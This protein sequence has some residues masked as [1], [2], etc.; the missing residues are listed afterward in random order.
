MPLK[1]DSSNKAR[2][3]NMEIERKAG[4]PEKQAEAIGYAEQRRAKA[5]GLAKG[6]DVEIGPVTV[7]SKHAV[8]L[9]PMSVQA[10]SPETRNA[11]LK[12]EDRPVQT[13]PYGNALVGAI[14]GGIAGAFRGAPEGALESVTKYARP[15]PDK[16]MQMAIPPLREM[17]EAA[18]QRLIA[19]PPL[20]HYAYGGAISPQHELQRL[21]ADVKPDPNEVYI[22]GPAAAKQSV[23]DELTPADASQ[24]ARHNRMQW[25]QDH[26]PKGEYG[27]KP[28]PADTGAV[29]LARGGAVPSVPHHAQASL[30]WPLAHL[31]EQG[32]RQQSY[33]LG[34]H[35]KHHFAE[36]G[37]VGSSPAGDDEKAAIEVGSHAR[38][39]EPTPE[40]VKRV[41]DLYTE[42]GAQGERGEKPAELHRPAAAIKAPTPITPAMAPA[43][44]SPLPPP[45]PPAPKP[46]TG[47]PEAAAAS[48]PAMP[49][50]SPEEEIEKERREERY[51]ALHPSIGM[52][53][54]RA[55][56]N[57]FKGFGGAPVTDY[58]AQDQGNA[59]AANENAQQRLTMLHSGQD[60]AHKL[61][62]ESPDSARAFA[63]KTALSS[64]LG[65][66]KEQFSGIAQE[67]LG[68]LASGILAVRNA[69]SKDEAAAATLALKQQIEA[70][71]ASQKDRELDISQ[72]RANATRKAA[73]SNVQMHEARIL[74]PVSRAL[75]TATSD[76]RKNADQ[77]QKVDTNLARM[78]KSGVA[79]NVDVAAMAADLAALMRNGSATETE[80]AAVLPQSLQ[81]R[82]AGLVQYASGKSQ[83]T[84]LA[85]MTVQQFGELARSVKQAVNQ[86]YSRNVNNALGAYGHL[87][88][89]FP[90]QFKMWREQAARGLPVSTY[91]AGPAEGG[92]GSEQ[93]LYDAGVPIE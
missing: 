67:D 52:S 54:R 15:D 4:R 2:D 59:K 44:A 85:G 66:S 92:S 41:H 80:I 68:S 75:V 9:P 61:A 83:D 39:A 62:A 79:N 56:S 31:S 32:R 23:Q 40:E 34:L 22:S 53:I 84:G 81:G 38:S 65:V 76:Q 24:H 74:A 17:Q 6:G 50:T 49:P 93:D 45:A 8:E 29:A 16:T 69:K 72:Q 71:H 36:G 55:L 13:D 10:E 27:L 28:H 7:E 63:V 88:G 3:I 90:S 91:D 33:A 77:L 25:L 5:K 82:L 26:A 64:I 43:T 48:K 78:Q 46:P 57:G 37:V 60:Q 70:L 89:Q 42:D 20:P 58:N 11:R 1:T 86:S 18:A 12:A 14:G 19:K 35:M 73:D 30:R 21:R 51:A 87:E 47:Q